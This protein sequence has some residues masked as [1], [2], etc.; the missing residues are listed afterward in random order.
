[1]A[2]AEQQAFMTRLI[3]D[4]E[5]RHGFMAGDRKAIAVDHGLDESDW[6]ILQIVN[7]EQLDRAAYGF[8][9]D[10]LGKRYAEFQVFIDHLELYGDK[11]EF[12]NAFDQAYWKGFIARPM[13]LD[14]LLDFGA[15]WVV[16]R[17]LPRHLLD[18]VRFCH[19]T[20]TLAATPRVEVEGAFEE[21]PESIR[22]WHRVQ[23]RRPY[24]IVPFSTDVLAIARA[25]PTPGDAYW[26][27]PPT[28]LLLQKSWELF[29]RSHAWRKEDVGFLSCLLEEEELPALDVLV[30][31]PSG[32]LDVAS[33]ALEEAWR[34]GMVHL[35]E[36]RHFQVYDV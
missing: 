11:D 14:R 9:G 7:L 13:E 10:R 8:R 35:R 32:D 30:N 3:R 29:N 36:P 6:E 1:M 18:L 25:T 23:L 24:R 28:Q 12:L 15:R 27:S 31:H 5:F 26:E 4:H 33:R 17:E 16:S 19:V 34:A 21:L 2:L 20:C 22:A